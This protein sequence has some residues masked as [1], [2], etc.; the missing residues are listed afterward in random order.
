MRTFTFAYTGLTH[1]PS[2][3]ESNQAAPAIQP[4]YNVL[5][6]EHLDMLDG[7]GGVGRVEAG[8]QEELQ[9]VVIAGCD[10]GE[11]RAVE[12][13]DRDPALQQGHQGHA[14][15][16]ALELNSLTVITF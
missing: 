3:E 10:G 8:I 15:G 6:N 11:E 1:S 2:N 9:D 4:S 5:Q 13:G 14:A 7:N 16:P 12:G